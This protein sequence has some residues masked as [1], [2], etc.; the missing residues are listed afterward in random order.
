MRSSRRLQSLSSDIRKDDLIDK[1]NMAIK[2]YVTPL[3]SGGIAGV[4]SLVY[5][6]GPWGKFHGK[7]R[8]CNSPPCPSG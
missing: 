2:A 7:E 6:A 8:A 1:F 4:R 5:E 3:E